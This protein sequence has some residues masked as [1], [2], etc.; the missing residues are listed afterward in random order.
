MLL[1]PLAAVALFFVLP[2]YIAGPLWFLIAGGILYARWRLHRSVQFPP[3]TGIESMAGRTAIV[4]EPLCPVGTIRYRGEIWRAV[5]DEPVRASAR[6]TIVRVERMP[7]GFTAVVSL[8]DRA[9]SNPSKGV[10]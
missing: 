9:A 4:V 2:V 7:E 10:R 6:V 1:L 8:L 5:S 3:L